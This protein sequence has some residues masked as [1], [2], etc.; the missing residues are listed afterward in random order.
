MAA[1]ASSGAPLASP[2]LPAPPPGLCVTGSR[3]H[4]DR[5]TESSLAG[6]PAPASRFPAAMSPPPSGRVPEKAAA[7]SLARDPWAER[8]DSLLVRY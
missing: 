2:Y 7:C 8:T 6:D 3:F 5:D 1:Q 4:A